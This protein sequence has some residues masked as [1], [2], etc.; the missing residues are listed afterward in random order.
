MPTHYT[1]I[2]ASVPRDLIFPAVVALFFFSLQ[3]KADTK[4]PV[5]C[6]LIRLLQDKN[7]SVKV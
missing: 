1:V 7:L 5:Y 3:I 4:R 6:S 2:L